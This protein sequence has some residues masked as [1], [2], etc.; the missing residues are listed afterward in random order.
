MIRRSDEFMQTI[1]QTLKKETEKEAY[2][3]TVETD[4]QY[5]NPSKSTKSERSQRLAESIKDGPSMPR[6]GLMAAK[7]PAADK[8]RLSVVVI[9]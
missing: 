2:N 3:L 1:A 8:T 9:K 6:E 5:R 7:A 4:C